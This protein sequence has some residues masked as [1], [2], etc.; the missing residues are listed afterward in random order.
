MRVVAA[1]RSRVHTLAFS[2]DGRRLASVAGVGTTVHLWDLATGRPAQRLRGHAAPVAAV[3]FAPDA[4]RLA[5]VDS[6][7]SILLWD[8]AESGNYVRRPE[9]LRPGAFAARGLAFSPDGRWLAA[10]GYGL[11]VWDLAGGKKVEWST[12]RPTLWRRLLRPVYPVDVILALAFSPD[13]RWLVWSEPGGQAVHRRDL[14][15]GQVERGWL[16]PL[17]AHAAGLAFSADGAVL[18]V[19]AGWGVTLFDT[20]TATRLRELRG[21]RGLI[22]E[23]AWLPGGR[24]LATASNDQ[25]VRFWDADAGREASQ[26]AWGIGK[27]RAV[28]FAA[29]GLTV[30]A[31]GEHGRIVL[32]DVDEG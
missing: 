10:G 22:W 32:W 2:P 27:V 24:T 13:G 12:H 1:H 9:P 26:F 20:V 5:S 25:T 11:H 30:A 31:G 4:G 6:Q 8:R 23:L 7:S 14:A 18:A 28:A 15:S 17:A 19:V 29:D 16:P 21:H 3:A